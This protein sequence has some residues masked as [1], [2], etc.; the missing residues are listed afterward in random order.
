MKAHNDSTKSVIAAESDVTVGCLRRSPRA[1]ATTKHRKHRRRWFSGA[2]VDTPPYQ[3]RVHNDWEKPRDRY[4]REGT[5]WNKETD[6]AARVGRWEVLSK[7][8]L[9]MCDFVISDK[10]NIRAKS[11]KAIA[12]S[13][14][15]LMCDNFSVDKYHNSVACM[16]PRADK[17]PSLRITSSNICSNLA[18]SV[19][20]QPAFYFFFFFPPGFRAFLAFN[21]NRSF[22]GEN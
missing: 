13:S 1:S 16:M 20:T 2:I 7:S 14:L 17:S 8:N 11:S 19:V 6:V 9:E 4:S 12:Q 18:G 15:R 10:V 5:G 3:W 21:W 22:S